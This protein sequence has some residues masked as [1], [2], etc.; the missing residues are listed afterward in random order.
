M[1]FAFKDD[2]KVESTF[3]RQRSAL[4]SILRLE[5]VS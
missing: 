3:Y 2:R 1:K 5:T 4:P